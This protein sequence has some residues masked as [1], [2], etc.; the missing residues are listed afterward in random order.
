MKMDRQ[1]G[2]CDNLINVSSGYARCSPWE[3]Y[4]GDQPSSSFNA[5]TMSRFRFTSRC[6]ANLENLR[7]EEMD[8]K[9]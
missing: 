8:R 7:A 6:C 3:I 4:S 1:I 5:T 9:N 2:S